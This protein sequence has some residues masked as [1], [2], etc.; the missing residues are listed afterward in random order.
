[1]LHSYWTLNTY[2]HVNFQIMSERQKMLMLSM[3]YHTAFICYDWLNTLHGW[4]SSWYTRNSW[5]FKISPEISKFRS[6]RKCLAYDHL[7][8]CGCSVQLT[9][10]IWGKLEYKCGHFWTFS[11]REIQNFLQPWWNN[12]K[13]ISRSS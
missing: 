6:F 1:M 11:G 10:K 8:V 5:F 4:K 7:K 2:M 9:N 3:T 13:I 12:Y